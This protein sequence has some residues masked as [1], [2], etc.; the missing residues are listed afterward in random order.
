MHL[1]F[2]KERTGKQDEHVLHSMRHA[3]SRRNDT[4]SSSVVDQKLCFTTS[5]H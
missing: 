1:D 2:L 3:Q 4:Y 5:I